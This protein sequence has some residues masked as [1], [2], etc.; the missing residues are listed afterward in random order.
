MWWERA[1]ILA[2]AMAIDL[3]WGDPPNRFHPVAWMGSFIAWWKPRAPASGPWVRF[4]YGAG[5]VVVGGALFS[6]PLYF[7][8]PLDVNR[9]AYILINAFLLKAILSYR[10]LV[11]AA[12]EVRDALAA[13]HLDE[14]RRRLAWHLVSRDTSRLEEGLV[15]AATVE[16]VAEN[17]TDGLASPL[18]F[19]LIGG[20][21]AAWAYRFV[22]TCD[23]MLGYHDPLHEH[24]GKFAARLDDLLNLIPA[25][26][27]ANIMSIS[28]WLA[29]ENG[30][31]A[32]QVMAAQHGR[33]P[34]P[35]AGWTMSAMAGALGVTL[36]KV[37]Y[38]RLQGGNGPL[39]PETI[40]RALRVAGGTAALIVAF[41]LTI[42][43]L[44]DL[45]LRI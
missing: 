41:C 34:S 11:R 6:L 29:G 2:L 40:D 17:L 26:L 37:G 18:F 1:A 8:L 31:G 10:G 36:E 12:R 16:S 30:A 14:A 23:S 42:M 19:Y 7:L 43:A 39:G 13:G 44:V 35:N 4:A 27:A 22:N 25:R 45:L 3:L 38:Y 5:W 24:L 21:P 15:A 33:T 28:A 9:G 32:W 20:L